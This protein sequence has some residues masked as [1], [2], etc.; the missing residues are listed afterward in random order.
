MGMSILEIE[1]RLKHINFMLDYDYGNRESDPATQRGQLDR[2]RC[3]RSIPRDRDLPMLMY[4]CYTT[5]QRM[6]DAQSREGARQHQGDPHDRIPGQPASAKA[7][8]H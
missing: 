3:R 4:W 8:G 7:P 5:L 2:R 6:T 1:N